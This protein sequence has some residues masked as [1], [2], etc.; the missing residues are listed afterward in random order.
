[1]DGTL[2]RVRNCQRPRYGFYVD[3]VIDSF[4]ATA[5]L[6]GLA[7][8]GYMHPWIAAG[9]LIAFLLLS[10]E[11]YLA[12]YTLGAFRLSHFK[13]SP[14][15]LR[16]LLALGNVIVLFRPLVLGG[17][18]RLFDLGGAVGIVGMFL[19]LLLSF[20]RNTGELYRKEP[21]R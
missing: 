13:W 9:L 19:I 5:L 6:G 4:G 15:E 10:I 3:H 16:I 8:S 14:T 12:S 7:L 18:Y 21:L 20:I 2:A 11:V 1:M 17:R